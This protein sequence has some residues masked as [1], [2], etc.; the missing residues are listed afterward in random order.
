MKLQE[1]IDLVLSYESAKDDW[2]N[3]HSSDEWKLANRVSFIVMREG[4]RKHV[5]C[6]CLE[7]LFIM[8]KSLNKNQIQKKQ[9]VMNGKFKLKNG[10]TLKSHGCDILTA[11]NCT[12]EKAIKVLKKNPKVLDKFESYPSNWK[13]LC[14]SNEDNSNDSLSIND[15][16]RESELKELGD[17]VLRTLAN[18]VSEKSGKRKAHHKA[19]TDKLIKYII[20][21]E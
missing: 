15:S 19:G 18:E 7:D 2:R 14:G 6:G 17:D 1:E 16:G 9:K 5:N 11:D 12:D 4:L 3:D 10:I 13:E 8:L 20:D 21:N